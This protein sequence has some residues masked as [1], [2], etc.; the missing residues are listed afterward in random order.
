MCRLNPIDVRNHKWQRLHVITL[1]HSYSHWPEMFV[2]NLISIRRY[3]YIYIKKTLNQYISIPSCSS[4]LIDFCHLSR[5]VVEGLLHSGS[6]GRPLGLLPNVPGSSDWTILDHWEAKW[7]R[8]WVRQIWLR[9]AVLRYCQVNQDAWQE[10]RDDGEVRRKTH[11][12]P[13]W[14]VLDIGGWV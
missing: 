3:D 1:A 5:G 2:S 11:A 8:K 9:D 12:N 6:P 7:V 14:V 13:F 10:N 4:P